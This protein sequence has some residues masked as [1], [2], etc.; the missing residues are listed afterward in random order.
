M[1]SADDVK[2]TV[3]AAEPDTFFNTPSDAGVDRGVT[4]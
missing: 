2:R 1:V 3:L 4:P